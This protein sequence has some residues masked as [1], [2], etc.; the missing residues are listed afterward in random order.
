MADI[1]AR[2]TLILGGC[3][4][5]HVATAWIGL[6]G[7]F[8]VSCSSAIFPAENGIS[9]RSCMILRNLRKYLSLSATLPV[10]WLALMRVCEP[11]T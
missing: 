7:P 2:N 9:K 8:I 1:T 6:F 11:C 4:R 5:T 3:L 10:C